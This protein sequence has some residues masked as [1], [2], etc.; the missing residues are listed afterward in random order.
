MNRKL[1]A[2]AISVGTFIGAAGT[3]AAG[4]ITGNGEPIDINARSI[5]VFSGLDD[6]DP[7]PFGR[8]QSFGQ[9]PKEFRPPVGTHDHP[10]TACNPTRGYDLHD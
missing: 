6:P 1:L 2:L 8:V 4:E 10:G 7:D 5:C 3:A 9:I